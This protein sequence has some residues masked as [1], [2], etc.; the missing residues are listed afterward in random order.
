LLGTVSPTNPNDAWFFKTLQDNVPITVVLDY[1]AE[2][3]DTFVFVN[4]LM[5]DANKPLAVVGVGLSLQD[6]S[7]IFAGYKYG[8]GSSLWLI[9][10]Q[11]EIYLSDRFDHN[12]TNIRDHLPGGVAEQVI[13]SGERDNQSVE[14]ADANNTRYDLI[15]Y[16]LKTADWRLVV[17]V[18][19][20][21]TIGFLRTIQ[22]NTAIAVLIAL[23]SIVFFFFY[24]SRK[25]ANPYKRALQINE[26]LEKLIAL[27]TKELAARN[28]N[29][30]DSIAYAKRIQE[31]VLP[32]D[33]QLDS[34]LTDYFVLWKP[35]DVVGGDFYW[36]RAFPSGYMIA[37]GDCTGHGVPGAFMT[38][39]AISALNQ[40]ADAEHLDH[41]GRLLGLLNR[42]LKRTL[43]QEKR[44]GLTDDGLDLGV[45]CVVGNRV[46][47]AG[48]RCSVYIA[49]GEGVRTI[50]G[51]KRSVG[52]RRT[53]ADHRY[54]ETGHHALPGDCF[55]ITTDGY[56][57]Q[58]GGEHDY[59]FGKTRFQAVIERCRHLP[60]T[61]QAGIFEEQLQS[62]MQAS[63]QRDDITVV[64]FRLNEGGNLD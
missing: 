30:M 40:L 11:G 49:T 25:L 60:M 35:R 50:R 16:P 42:E 9:D 44:E 29:I 57:D 17:Q 52:Y 13:A 2:R 36:A 6:L 4:A 7:N 59:S 61:A 46:V 54:T 51:D 1:N 55:Y 15:S 37:V 19:R 24:V 41:P 58:N 32:E 48:A 21:A 62:Y 53:S 63:R 12:G 8:E 3:G 45:C 38:M 18:P 5:Y 26:E 43:H 10:N 47:F 64:A 22:F 39:L 20:S 56:P 31:S 27:R 14:F 23:I 28:E 34:L 33:A